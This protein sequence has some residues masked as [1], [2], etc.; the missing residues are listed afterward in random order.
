MMALDE[1]DQLPEETAFEK[2]KA[3]QNHFLSLFYSSDFHTPKTISKKQ[4]NYVKRGYTPMIASDRHPHFFQLL[5]K[6]GSEVAAED[7][8]R[9]WLN[10]A[11][12]SGKFEIRHLHGILHPMKIA[13][14]SS[15]LGNGHSAQILKDIEDDLEHFIKHFVPCMEGSN[16][17]TGDDLKWLKRF[18]CAYWTFLKNPEKTLLDSL[19]LHLYSHDEWS[20]ILLAEHFTFLSGILV[21]N[22]P[23]HHVIQYLHSPFEE[24]SP[25]SSSFIDI[26]QNLRLPSL[27]QAQHKILL[28][29]N[30]EHNYATSFPFH[31]IISR[32]ESESSADPHNLS[33]LHY[34]LAIDKLR[35]GE[36]ILGDV[37]ERFNL[38]KDFL[39]TYCGDSTRLSALVK[40]I[41]QHSSDLRPMEYR[42]TYF[43]IGLSNLVKKSFQSGDNENVLTETFMKNIHAQGRGDY[44]WEDGYPKS[45]LKP[46]FSK[47]EQLFDE[48]VNLEHTYIKNRN[49]QISNKHKNSSPDYLSSGMY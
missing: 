20:P 15:N 28:S 3:Q 26:L 27:D 16:S 6:P 41:V 7:A 19:Y 49:L 35:K 8:L 42:S 37:E 31:L 23:R 18:Y 25:P 9:L 44:Q 10:L 24:K 4:M 13:Y 46:T 48:K 11:V 32:Y 34:C 2:Y 12:N 29:Y 17:F 14:R 5:C 40:R 47:V 30:T 45:P 21:E 1:H 38:L 33:D 43:W 22:D 39:E 36:M